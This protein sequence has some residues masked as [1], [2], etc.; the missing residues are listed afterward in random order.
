MDAGCITC[1]LPMHFPGTGPVHVKAH[2]SS[3]DQKMQARVGAARGV[4]VW[5]SQ[6]DRAELGQYQGP[7]N[8]QGTQPGYMRVG[9]FVI[10]DPHVYTPELNG[11]THA[12]CT[13]FNCRSLS[14][15]TE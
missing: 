15:E 12:Y 3:L 8:T 1:L 14:M 2:G 11:Q 7:A 10:Q 9:D 4:C 13:L 6:P 5:A